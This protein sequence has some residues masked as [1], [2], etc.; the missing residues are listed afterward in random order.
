MSNFWKDLRDKL[1]YR[2]DE[3]KNW[4]VGDKKLI[5]DSV[6]EHKDDWDS[7]FEGVEEM[8]DEEVSTKPS[9][10]VVGFFWV[11]FVFL[12]V[13]LVVLYLSFQIGRNRVSSD[14]IVIDVATRAFVAS[15]E[16]F[17]VTVS[18]KNLNNVEINDA[19]FV[20]A[21][22][23]SSGN[24]V[25]SNHVEIGDIGARSAKG[26]SSAISVFGYLGEKKKV[27]VRLFYGIPGSNATFFK[28]KEFE[29]E[30]KSTP[31]SLSVDAPEVSTSGQDYYLKVIVKN[32][33][34]SVQPNV[35]LKVDYPVNFVFEKSSVATFNDDSTWNLGDLDPGESARVDIFGKFIG[36]VD[37][38]SVFEMQVG[39]GDD[40][41]NIATLLQTNTFSVFVDRGFLDVNFIVNGVM[42]NDAV[43]SVSAGEDVNIDIGCLNVS[44]FAVFNPRIVVDIKG[45]LI[46]YVDVE[47]GGAVYDREAGTIE[48]DGDL[49]K[50][51]DDGLAPGDECLVGFGL[52]FSENIPISIRRPNIV[53]SADVYGEDD[54]GVEKVLRSV[55][56]AELRLNSPVSFST[57]LLPHD[58]EYPMVE[59]SET[60]FEVLVSVMNGNNRI[61]DAK[62]E[63]PLADLVKYVGGDTGYGSIEYV[64]D[65]NKVV[66]DIGSIARMVGYD[67]R[68]K[69]TASIKISVVPPTSYVG[70][71]VPLTGNIT[72]SGVDGYSGAVYNI[73]YKGLDSGS[74]AN[75]SPGTGRV[76]SK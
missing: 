18:V 35:V 43:Y 40:D 36:V 34:S 52:V 22:E 11:S 28:V 25:V 60:V 30:I 75:S 32:E 41:G 21:Y 42:D 13:A 53:L 3:G 24:E 9:S 47:Y 33:S 74:V 55:A 64:E 54:L 76:L 38:F 16:K 2:S 71:E 73:T 7:K 20:L 31:L 8:Q 65:D 29:V 67:G 17:P 69:L 66:W 58:G 51:G 4:D 14:S 23:D 27:E 37:D 10:F 26:G 46:D 61:D 59:G 1:L 56:V 12:M 72:F 62:I 70:L 15:G 19:Y 45:S 63:I 6:G 68:D 44:D 39:I 50:V 48:F 5:K 57:I 49:M